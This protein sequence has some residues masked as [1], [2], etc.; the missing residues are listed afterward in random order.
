MIVEFPGPSV[1]SDTLE[2]RRRFLV[3]VGPAALGALTVGAVL[4]PAAALADTC[5]VEPWGKIF[6]R[7]RLSG[8]GGRKAGAGVVLAIFGGAV[9]WSYKSQGILGGLALM[10]SG[11]L[12]LT[13][14]TAKQCLSDVMDDINDI[15]K[16]F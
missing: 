2:E 9:L 14:P 5:S 6:P 1:S 8:E 3:G 10:I 15:L 11:G 12:L 13:Q 16:S 4:P 7:V